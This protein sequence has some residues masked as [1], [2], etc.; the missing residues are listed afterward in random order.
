MWL[1]NKDGRCEAYVKLL[2][3]FIDCSSKASEWGNVIYW[4]TFVLKNVRQEVAASHRSW[5]IYVRERWQFRAFFAHLMLYNTLRQ[6]LHTVFYLSYSPEVSG[7]FFL[8][9]KWN[10]SLKLWC[11]GKYGKSQ[12][13]SVDFSPSQIYILALIFSSSSVKIYCCKQT[14]SWSFLLFDS[15]TK[16]ASY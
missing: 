16:I 6:F 2:S 8:S 12:G 1:K 4:P 9:W 14:R 5:C 10:N 3:I 15:S 13:I 7:P 11:N